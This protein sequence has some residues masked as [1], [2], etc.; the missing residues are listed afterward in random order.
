MNIINSDASAKVPNIYFFDRWWFSSCRFSC[1]FSLF[2]WSRDCLF[3]A[4]FAFV[5]VAVVVVVAAA[6]AYVVAVVAAIVVVAAVAVAVAVVVVAVG[7]VVLAVAVAA[8]G[9]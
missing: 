1:R 7:A 6:V 9:E 4:Y 8:D 2:S 3:P 5:V